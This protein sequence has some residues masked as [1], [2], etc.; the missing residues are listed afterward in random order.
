MLRTPTVR[1]PPRAKRRCCASR[2]P[3]DHRFGP[4]LLHDTQRPMGKPEVDGLVWFVQVQTFR[5]QSWVRTRLPIPPCPYQ[6]QLRGHPRL[7]PIFHAQGRLGGKSRSR[8]TTNAYSGGSTRNMRFKLL[9]RS[10]GKRKKRYNLLTHV[11][12]AC[13]A[14]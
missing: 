11:E 8:R 6:A 14:S 4:H 1:S 9:R 3:L 12:S 10:S 5:S 2:A 13:R 7:E